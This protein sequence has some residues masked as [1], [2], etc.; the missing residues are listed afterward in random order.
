[1]PV[2]EKTFEQLA[3]EDGRSTWELVGGRLREKPGMT[4]EHNEAVYQLGLQLGNQLPRE[5]FR[6]RADAGYV[7]RT[8]ANYFGPDLM[9]IPA[10][11]AEALRDTHR[12][13]TYDEPLPF[14]AEVW[15]PSTGAYDIDTKFPEYQA[16]GDLEIWRI[17]PYDRSVTAWRRQPDG[18]YRESQYRGGRAPIE[19]LP[20]VEIDLDSLFR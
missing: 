2:T 20:G 11:M 5:H 10:A 12:L 14:V 17:H 3:L 8:S 18:S 6:I 19:S 7:R 15:S 1:M 4:M 16:R 13:E 9:V